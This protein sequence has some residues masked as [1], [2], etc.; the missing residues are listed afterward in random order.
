MRNLN[1]YTK[2]DPTRRK[3]LLTTSIH[4]LMTFWKYIRI[5]LNI[6]Q[7][8]FSILSM[9]QYNTI[10]VFFIPVQRKETIQFLLAK[11]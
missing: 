6:Y 9:K 5:W 4:V 8:K 2:G 3:R 7:L 11:I 10:F 1:N